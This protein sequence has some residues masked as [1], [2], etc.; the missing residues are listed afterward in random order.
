VTYD[1]FDYSTYG[2]RS[3]GC[4]HRHRSVVAADR[5]LVAGRNSFRRAGAEFDREIRILT[6]ADETPPVTPDPSSEFLQDRLLD[7]PDGEW[8]LLVG[9]RIASESAGR[10]GE[11]R[12]FR[13]L[14]TWTRPEFLATASGDLERSAFYLR[15]LGSI[16]AYETGKTLRRLSSWW[17]RSGWDREKRWL[18][19]VD[20]LTAEVG[21]LGPY[22]VDSY[23]IFV[24]GETDVETT[25][26]VLAAALNRTKK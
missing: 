19:T 13:V 9:C 17:F 7:W 14:R 10:V 2:P 11:E 22:A 8:A 15:G 26:P 16:T 25:D 3:G 21:G 20:R 4:G 12:A 5:C 24:L 6:A 23:R 1:L 18:P